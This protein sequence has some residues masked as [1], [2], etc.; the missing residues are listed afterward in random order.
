MIT[1]RWKLEG[2]EWLGAA[3]CVSVLLGL[4]FYQFIHLPLRAGLQETAAEN[5]RVR[6]TVVSVENYQNAHLDFAAFEKDLREQQTRAGHA[7]P[8]QLE[9]GTFLTEIQQQAL[10][11]QVQ[12]QGVIPGK[13]E[14]VDHVKVLPIQLKFHC[15]YFAL[16]SF[17]RDLQESDRYISVKQTTVQMKDGLLDCEMVLNIFA[18]ET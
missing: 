3:A 15:S 12:L 10:R 18:M 13:V 11:H 2:R 4:G 14:E 6:T 9:Q 17:L 5:M 8:A 16:L 7:L 1:M